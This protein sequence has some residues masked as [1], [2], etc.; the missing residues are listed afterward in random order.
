[1]FE[2]APKNLKS[3]AAAR[4]LIPKLRPK[5]AKLGLLIW[6]KR[7]RRV[8]V[9]VENE[10]IGLIVFL[11]VMRNP[12]FEPGACDVH[13]PPVSLDW[14][15][16]A[17]AGE[18]LL[19]SCKSLRELAGIFHDHEAYASMDPDREIYRVRSWMP[20][21]PGTEGGLFW[22]VT[23]LQPGKVGDEYFMT[24]GHRHANSTRAEYYATVSGTGMLIRM[25]TDRHTWGELMT[26]G[27]LHYVRGEHAHRVAN[28]GSVPLVFWACWGSDAGYDYGMIVERGFGARLVER[29]GQPTFVTGE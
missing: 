3:Q 28:T 5:Q 29:D 17:L 10:H 20:V 25:D 14:L 24:H 1:M 6:R 27:T 18:G 21:G 22:G 26:P 16:G 15:R 23:L 11:P 4:R 19:E 13:T 8:I 9:I 12:A 7:T 2:S